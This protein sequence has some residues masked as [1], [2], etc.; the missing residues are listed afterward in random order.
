MTPAS[1]RPINFHRIKAQL[2]LSDSARLFNR[3]C[4]YRKKDLCV[5]SVEVYVIFIEDTTKQNIDPCGTSYSTFL[6]RISASSVTPIRCQTIY[7]YIKLC[8][9]KFFD[10]GL[11]VVFAFLGF[12]VQHLQLGM[13]DL[14]VVSVEMYVVFIEDVTKADHID[15][16]ERCSVIYL[17][18]H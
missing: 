10:S 14:R 16:G 4:G 15:S 18:P 3:H 17:S 7:C 9:L 5:I 2:T 6:S 8:Q 12:T 1:Y 13:K 11:R